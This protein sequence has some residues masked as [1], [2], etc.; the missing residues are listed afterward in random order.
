MLKAKREEDFSWFDA[1]LK[2]VSYMV[3]MVRRSKNGFWKNMLT[4]KK[5]RLQQGSAELVEFDLTS[6]RKEIYLL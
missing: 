4:V 2:E 1:F 5:M 6:F 3:T